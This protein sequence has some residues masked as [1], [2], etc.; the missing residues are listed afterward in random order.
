MFTFL[1]PL[2]FGF[3]CHLAS[4]FTT[5]F[6]CRWGERGGSLITLV[7]RNFLGIPVWAIGFGMA[8]HVSSPFLLGPKMALK[9][10]GWFLIA[11]GGV[12]ILI[13]LF[14]IRWRAASPSTQDRLVQS[15]LYAHVRH[16][17]HSGT[18]LEFLGVF[19]LKPTYAVAVACVLGFFWVWL[20]TRAE[21][22]DL[23][24]RL[25][26]YQEYMN[27]IPRFFPRLRK[28]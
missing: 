2:L 20:Q 10:L 12:I 28:R 16:P 6:S 9:I 26:K 18:F 7:L 27:R 25:P 5:A 4:A 17:I 13:A 11:V 14:V 3:S 22:Y 8:I 15:G 23:L 19:C 24:Q 1:F 21:E